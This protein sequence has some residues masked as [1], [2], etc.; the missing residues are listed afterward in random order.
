MYTVKNIFIECACQ[1]PNS[2]GNLRALIA[3]CCNQDVSW[4]FEHSNMPL[5]Q[6][7]YDLIKQGADA[8]H[9][10]VPFARIKGYKEFFGLD[11]TIANT[12]EPRPETELI[13]DSVLENY[14]G[15]AASVLDL[16]VGSG[17][18]LLSILHHATQMTGVGVDIDAAALATASLNAQ[19]LCL[20]E[21]VSF[22]QTCMRQFCFSEKFH[23]ITSNPPYIPSNEI[24]SLDDNVIHYDPRQSLDGGE[25]GLSYYRDIFN[26]APLLLNDRGILVVEIGHNQYDAIKKIALWDVRCCLIKVQKDLQGFDRCLIF[27][28]N[29]EN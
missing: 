14:Q 11:F 9:R 15:G 16:G 23:Y 17:C 22:I 5:S 2:V 28:Y 18:I 29:I 10:G 3:H 12:L 24:S 1:F 25:D 13:V 8:L 19:K 6:N 27:R 7:V 26:I 21:R 20:S 4:T